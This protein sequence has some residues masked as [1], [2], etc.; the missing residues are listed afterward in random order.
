MLRCLVLVARQLES[1]S[2]KSTDP[3]LPKLSDRDAGGT[4]GASPWQPARPYQQGPDSIHNTC[5][6]V[7]PIESH[8]CCVKSHH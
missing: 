1:N 7:C 2:S 5:C 8:L 3:I 6:Y 4:G